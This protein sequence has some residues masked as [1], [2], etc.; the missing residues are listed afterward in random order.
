MV[1]SK[2]GI[3]RELKKVQK[4]LSKRKS[5][6]ADWCYLYGSQQAL[7][8]ALKDNAMRPSKV[9]GYVLRKEKP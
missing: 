4:L 2:I 1:R 8:W 7:A 5:Q 9:F 6:N 3:K